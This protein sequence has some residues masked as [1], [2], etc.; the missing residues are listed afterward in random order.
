[1]GWPDITGRETPVVCSRRPAVSGGAWTTL[2]TAIRENYEQQLDRFSARRASADSP[3]T[4]RDKTARRGSVSRLLIG[5]GRQ[6][7]ASVQS[8]DL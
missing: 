3:K 7:I 8:Y 4:V 5:P 1:M 2:D 6:A